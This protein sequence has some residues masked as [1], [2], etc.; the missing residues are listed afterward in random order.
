MAMNERKAEIVR[1]TSLKI[2]TPFG[3]EHE[4]S[5]R[6]GRSFLLTKEDLRLLSENV[7]GTIVIDHQDGRTII[8][9]TF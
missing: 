7:H 4:I 9:Q 5:K 2:Q 3:G 1:V 6:N 8:D